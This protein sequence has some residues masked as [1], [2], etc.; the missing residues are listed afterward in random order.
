MNLPF[1]I[2]KKNPVFDE[3]KCSN[4]FLSFDKNE[5]KNK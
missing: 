4:N 2:A 5:K 3:S 1:T